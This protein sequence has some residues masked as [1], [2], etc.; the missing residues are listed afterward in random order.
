[1]TDPILQSLTKDLITPGLSQVETDADGTFYRK[2][3]VRGMHVG[4]LMGGLNAYTHLKYVDLRNN[5]I[6]SLKP[7]SLLNN[8]LAIDFRQN[9]IDDISGFESQPYLQIAQLDN[10]EVKDLSKFNHPHIKSLTMSKNRIKNF[11]NI[12]PDAVPALKMLDLNSNVIDSLIGVAVFA[13]LNILKLRGNKLTSLDGIQKLR[14]LQQLDVRENLLPNAKEVEKLVL[15]PSLRVLMATGNEAMYTED[16]L[17]QVVMY[18]PKLEVLDDRRITKVERD[19]AEVLEKQIA[20]EAAAK[21]AEEAAAAAEAAAAE[22]G[23]D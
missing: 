16:P 8:L 11:A 21:A 5:F 20:A 1:M 2:L 3:Q 22:A 18:L 17:V 19:A 12:N 10:N 6:S 13:N 14:H 4:D 9:I 7:L 23:E 15:L